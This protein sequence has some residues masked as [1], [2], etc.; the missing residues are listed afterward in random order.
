M[1][2]VFGTIVVGFFSGTLVTEMTV[3]GIISWKRFYLTASFYVLVAVAIVLYL[4]HKAR[5]KMESSVLEFRDA[6]YCVAYVRSKCIPEMAEKWRDRIRTGD[7]GELTR[8][9]AE[10]KE[11]LRDVHPD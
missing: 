6:D 8:A 2:S 1:F 7:G 5:F 10:L 4:Y 11:S 3:D 9:M